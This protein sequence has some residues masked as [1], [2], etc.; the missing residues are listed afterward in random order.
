VVSFGGGRRGSDGGTGLCCCQ[1]KRE[2]PR[3]GEGENGE[4]KIGAQ[5]G[6]VVGARGTGRSEQTAR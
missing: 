6:M 5:W 4:S 3:D 2:R 1:W